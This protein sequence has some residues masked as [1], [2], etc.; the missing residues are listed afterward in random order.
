VIGEE[1][2]DVYNTFTWATAGDN[3][4]IRFDAFCNPRKDTTGCIKKNCSQFRKTA[5]NIQFFIYIASL[6]TYNVE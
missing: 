5:I 6:G 2:V 3:L 4:K 1:A